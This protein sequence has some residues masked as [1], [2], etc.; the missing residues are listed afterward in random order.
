ML[1]YIISYDIIPYHRS[2]EALP[3][4]RVLLGGR[5]P[6]G[7]RRA[8]HLEGHDD[9]DNNSNNDNNND[10]DSNN[11]NDKKTAILLY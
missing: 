7:K 5:R 11:S 10:N 2:P 8:L 6:W 3:R 1:Y 4:R 9:N